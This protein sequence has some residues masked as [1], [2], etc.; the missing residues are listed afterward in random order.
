MQVRNSFIR[1][2]HAKK[3]AKNVLNIVSISHKEE[4]R[5][6]SSLPS[7][8]TVV[9]TTYTTFLLY[10]KP[11]HFFTFY[12]EQNDSDINSLECQTHRHRKIHWKY[13]ENKKKSRPK[14]CWKPGS[15]GKLARVSYSFFSS[16]QSGR[17]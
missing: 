2:K 10:Y 17:R 3:Y 14:Q 6:L 8:R 7:H 5:L 11:R 15:S 4:V 9:Q 1:K 12:A 16:F 13:L